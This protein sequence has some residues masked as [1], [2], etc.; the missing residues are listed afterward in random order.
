MHNDAEFP[1]SSWT[2]N[3][4]DTMAGQTGITTVESI[5]VGAAQGSVAAAVLDV[6]VVVVVVVGVDE[7]VLEVEEEEEEVVD[8]VVP[9]A[10]IQY[11]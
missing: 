5:T 3:V 8:A 11:K 7:E 6:A 9:F 10:H 4:A 2:I 1:L